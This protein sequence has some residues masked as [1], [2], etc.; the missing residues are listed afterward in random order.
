MESSKRHLT[1]LGASP[2]C[3]KGVK[4]DAQRAVAA[5]RKIDQASEIITKKV[6]LSAGIKVE[7]L[8]LSPKSR[9]A[10]D[11]D[12]LME[13]V[14]QK[15]PS[16]SKLQK[17]QLLSLVPA[18]W[19]TKETAEFFGTG[20][21]IVKNAQKLRQ[22]GILPVT[23]FKRKSSVLDSTKNIIKD[24]YCL[25][26]NSKV[27]PGIRDSVSISPGVYKQKRLILCD[28]SELYE[29]FKT[30]YKDLKVGLSMFYSLRPKWCV[31]AGGA[32]THQQCVCQIHQNFKLVVYA[33][34]IKKHYTE[35]IEECVCNVEDR[36]CM[37]R[38]CENCPTLI[39]IQDLIRHQIQVPEGLESEEEEFLKETVKFRQWKTTD[40]TEM[41]VQICKRSELI[42]IAAKQI[43]DLIPHNF[44][45]FSQASYV[46]K[47]REELSENKVM[48]AMDFSMNYNCLVQGA[49]QSYHWSP[50]QA[51]VHPTVV[52]FKN[53]NGEVV[54]KT[55]VFISEDLDHDVPIVQKFQEL[56][57][58]YIK[59]KFPKVTEVEYVTDGCCSQYKSK[60]YFKAL[61]D[62]EKTLKLKA[63]HSYHATAHGKCQSDADGGTVKREARRASLQRPS[64]KQI[65]SAMDLYNF[66]LQK[67]N[68]KFEFRFVSRWDVEPQRQ[69][70]RENMIKLETVPGTRSFHFFKPVSD[71]TIACWRVSNEQ[72]AEPALVHCLQKAERLKAAPVTP[73]TGMFVV[74][75]IAKNRYLGLVTD[76]YE[77][78]A[79]ADL[80]LLMPKLPAKVFY[81]P[82]DMKTASVPFPHLITDVTLQEKGDNMILTVILES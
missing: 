19:S 11:H 12:L 54:H 72:R 39:Q 25:D 38:L 49:V 45:A 63:S 65:I 6:C 79:E 26:E 52:Y 80:T 82:Q 36:C 57:V 2:L 10:K 68:E 40:R 34:N 27:M 75:R 16:A 81:W 67:L 1:L 71:D 48:V 18:S 41:V 78:E 42:E 15:L 43:N 44:I 14:K 46:K 7:D 20:R 8:P 66:C 32:G 55:I 3:L 64:D 59:E 50:K 4:T 74:A 58:E 5:K 51:T 61:C 53:D 22:G 35:L 37:L 33:L 76:V 21:T 56:T 31:F 47:S 70:Y 28:V 29:S 23:E 69:Q 24:F 9:K 62:H 77:E 30:K 60:G 17:Y 13:E 73:F